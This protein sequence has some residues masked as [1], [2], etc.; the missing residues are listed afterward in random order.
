MSFQNMTFTS[1]CVAIGLLLFGI[2]N[3]SASANEISNFQDALAKVQQYQ[4]QFELQQQR[5]QLAILNTQN[6]SLWQNPTFSIEQNGFSSSQEQELSVGI[7]QPLD[8]FGQ[9]K[10]NQEIA[11]ISKQQL[12]LK[13]QLWQAQSE[14]VVK[15][16]WAQYLKLK[17]PFLLS[18]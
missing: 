8:L 1:Q 10:L 11:S 9:R 17:H 5:H 14:M 13:E 16:A 18:R 2:Q 3:T 6:S 12:Q 15:Y 7:S 4:S